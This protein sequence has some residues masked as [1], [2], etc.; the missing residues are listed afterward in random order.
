MTA[1]GLL[2][3]LPQFGE[4]TRTF[5]Y[6]YVKLTLTSEQFAGVPDSE[7]EAILAKHLGTSIADIRRTLHSSLFL[8]QL[9]AP[10]E[11]TAQTAQRSTH[12]LAG[13]T[14]SRPN[15]QHPI[16]PT[17]HFY[18]YKGGQARS[19]I[20][21][22]LGIFLARDGWKV[23]VV[24]ADIE[25][26]SLDT[27]FA[28]TSKTPSSTLLGFSNNGGR[29]QPLTVY[30]AP[31]EDRGSVSLL[32]CWPSSSTYSIDAAAF[33]LR[34][35]LEPTILEMALH[36][37][38]D[39]AAGNDFDVLLVDHRT[40]LSPSILPS[41]AALPGPTVLTVRLDEQWHN[42]K[43]FLGL[44]LKSYPP[45]PGALVIWKPDNEDERA[46]QQRTYRQREELLE[47]LAEAY[48]N[49]RLW[50]DDDVSSVELSDHMV[51]WPYDEAFRLMRLPEPEMLGIQCREAV[52]RLR[53]LL[54]LGD[55]KTPQVASKPTS[56][57][58][59]RTTS[60]SG[61]RDQGDLIVTR[62]LRELLSPDNPYSYIL[63]RKGT[64]KTRLARE[65]SAR[66]LGEPLL[67][68]EDS[69]DPNGLRTSSP[70]VRDA[71]KEYEADTE[72]FWLAL[73]SAATSLP[74][75]ARN[76]LGPEFLDHLHRN[77]TTS[78]I[79]K[80]WSEL[81]TRRIFLLDSLETAFVSRQM[82]GFLG[83]LFRV[84][85]MLDSDPRA[86]DH[87]GFKLFLRRDLAQRSFTQN[88]EQQL[89]GKMLELSWDFQSILNFML[90]RMALN[91]WYGAHFPQ[92]LE[93]IQQRRAKIL[94]GE[95]ESLEGEQ[96]LKTA[97]PATVRRNNLLTATFLRT[98]FTDTAT[99]RAPISSPSGGD[100]RRY[101][102]RVFDEFIRLIPSDLKD[103][104]GSEMPAT[105]NEGKIHQSRIFAAHE[106]AAESYL[107]G[108]KQELAYVIDM[109][110]DMTEN[111]DL[112]DKLL[113]AFDGLQTPFQIE[114]RVAELSQS[115]GIPRESVRS[116]LEK[117]RDVGMFEPRPDAPGEWRAGR[118]FKS[119]LR[120]K[121]VRGR[122]SED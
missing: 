107:Q 49:D 76:L 108:L 35:S 74:S 103:Q 121:Y 9:V 55:S 29:M 16:I 47:L 58:G 28:A 102:P 117:M 44:V 110:E 2:A 42:A 122:Q 85:S 100:A 31:L 43:A 119:S 6:P 12:W 33:A 92:L 83:G 105:D 59:S 1:T 5:T 94:T 18:G 15:Q 54:G 75:T 120:M 89:Y 90:S 116:A 118:L 115:T 20:L 17:V 34:T 27:I 21:A 67:V 78:E 86:A 82:V 79:F 61:A 109:A 71:V 50:P 36:R 114:R 73:F 113:N 111:Q 38:A 22:S 23:L 8:L 24:D 19:T 52:A 41:I 30:T 14:N 46:F 32:N 84:L 53:S 56:L 45:L 26:P 25:A 60:I 96:I 77:Q 10:G 66:R 69:E 63:G 106:K 7:R 98:Y 93:G 39:Y 68:P 101:Y 51:L 80:R 65:I 57:I 99:E 97:F 70:E 64:G 40:G 13:L 3:A 4:L 62:A 48:Q 11:S 72:H 88:L 91:P 112:I 81:S 104:D 37:I 95:V 87:V